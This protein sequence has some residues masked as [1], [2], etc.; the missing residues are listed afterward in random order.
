MANLEEEPNESLTF[1]QA[2]RDRARD[3]GGWTIFYYAIA[4]LI[5]C[6]TL[7]ALSSITL[8]RCFDGIEVDTSHYRLFFQ[9]PESYVFVTFVRLLHNTAFTTT[10]I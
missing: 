4:H 5:G 3:H 8:K 6:V 10:Y 1:F 7:L 2:I 9:F